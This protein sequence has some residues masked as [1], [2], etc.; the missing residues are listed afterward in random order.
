M[1]TTQCPKKQRPD[2]V[3]SIFSSWKN[4]VSSLSFDILAQAKSSNV[5]W[6]S[7]YGCSLKLRHQGCPRRR[8]FSGYKRHG[9]WWQPLELGVMFHALMNLNGSHTWRNA[10]HG[11][12]VANKFVTDLDSDSTAMTPPILA[13]H[14]VPSLPPHQFSSLLFPLK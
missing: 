6:P 4:T 5:A 9:N 1:I 13:Q 12:W 3:F 7:L 10:A 14:T 11:Y 2:H 8:Q